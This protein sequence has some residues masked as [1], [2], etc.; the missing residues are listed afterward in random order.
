MFYTKA[1]GKGNFRRIDRPK[2][3]KGVLLDT[4]KQALT[5]LNKVGI[6]NSHTQTRS[7]SKEKGVVRVGIGK[8]Q[9]DTRSGAYV[10]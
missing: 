2:I 10:P 8:A 6:G 5:D 7:N 9:T 4:N 3:E 1:K